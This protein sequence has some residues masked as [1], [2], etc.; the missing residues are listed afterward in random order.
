MTKDNPEDIKVVFAEGCFDNFEGTQEELDAFV[1][2]INRMA[3]SGE[4]FEKSVPLDIDNM[5]T[6]EMIRLAESMGLDLS[7]FGIDADIEPRKLQ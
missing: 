3:E 1:A 6:E 7:E 2:E 5:D 4:I